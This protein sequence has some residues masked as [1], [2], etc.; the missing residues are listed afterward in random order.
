MSPKESANYKPQ[1]FG[2][3]PTKPRFFLEYPVFFDLQT[4]AKRQVLQLST[5]YEVF[6]ALCLRS[7]DHRNL[8]FASDISMH[9]INV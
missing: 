5:L 2:I 6:E 8:H 7:S 9:K 1:F 4:L 3:F